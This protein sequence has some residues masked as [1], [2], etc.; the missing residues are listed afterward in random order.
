MHLQNEMRIN[1]L[2]KFEITTKNNNSINK[3]YQK[4]IED[5]NQ[6]F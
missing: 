6:R 4:Y 2:C 3:K 1:R 5:I